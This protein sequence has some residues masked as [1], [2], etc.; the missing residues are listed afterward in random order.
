[1]AQEERSDECDVGWNELLGG[2]NDQWQVMKRRADETCQEHLNRPMEGIEA[3]S[4]Q[5]FM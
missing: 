4:L 3:A 1:M 2:A 5:S